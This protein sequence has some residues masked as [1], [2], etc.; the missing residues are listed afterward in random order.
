MD[1]YLN[2]LFRKYSF[3]LLVLSSGRTALGAPC[4]GANFALPGIITAED[5]RAQFSMSATESRVHADVTSA[6]EWIRRKES[7]R[8]RT[9][10]LEASHLVGE[11]SQIGIG[12][13]IIQRSS[14]GED[15]QGLGDLSLMAGHEFLSD[16]DYNPWRPKGI[17]FL[18]VL[19][20]TGR[21]LY[22]GNSDAASGAKGRGLWGAG[23]GLILT[24]TWSRWD[25]MLSTE[26]HRFEPRKVAIGERSRTLLPGDGLSAQLGTG[27]SVQQTRFG[28][29]AQWQ[30]EQATRIRGEDNSE[31][32]P[33]R[34][35]TLSLMLGQQIATWHSLQV[36]YAD[37][38]WLSSPSNTQLTRSM[39]LFWQ[40]RW[41]G[42]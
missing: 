19:A 2:K 32:T 34:L 31:A 23:A 9:L 42:L 17:A 13:P 4:C 39:T 14:A 22:D 5:T 41:E 21:S 16:W 3:S 7:D 33:R 18:T 28:I 1:E 15:S 35:S 26:A 37:Q 24:K 30:Y 25:A 36:V 12:L 10:R 38:T 6:G 40:Y 20:P 29:M 11:L 27:Y 8:T